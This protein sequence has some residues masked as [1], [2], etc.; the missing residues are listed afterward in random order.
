ML[1]GE[2]FE[3][4]GDRRERGEEFSLRA[5]VDDQPLNITERRDIQAGSDPGLFV[6]K[7]SAKGDTAIQNHVAA[8]G[9]LRRATRTLQ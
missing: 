9:L 5:A 1:L 3:A 4:H 7:T 2:I 6:I 8:P